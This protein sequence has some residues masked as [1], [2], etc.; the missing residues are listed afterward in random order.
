MTQC[1]KET[2]LTLLLVRAGA[3]NDAHKTGS[4]IDEN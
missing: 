2:E 1:I 4:E 3:L